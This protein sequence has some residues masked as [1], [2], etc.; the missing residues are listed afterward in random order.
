LDLCL[1]RYPSGREQFVTSALHCKG[2]RIRI[3]IRIRRRLDDDPHACHLA[4]A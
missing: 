1:D 3:R 4:A 2:N